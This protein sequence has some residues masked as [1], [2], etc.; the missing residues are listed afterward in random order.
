VDGRREPDGAGRARVV[1]A[2]RAVAVVFAA[3]GAASGGFATRIPW[4]QE[5]L[6]LGTGRLGSPWSSPPSAPPPRCP[7]RRGWPT[8]TGRVPRCGC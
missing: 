7:S 1:R 3:H 6:G 5:H 2:R 8:A 4:T